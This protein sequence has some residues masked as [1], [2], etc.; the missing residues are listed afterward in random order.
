MLN[1]KL[2]V[3]CI[4]IIIAL[5]LY[6]FY[7]N[8]FIGFLISRVLRLFFWSQGKSAGSIWVDI[9]AF[10]SVITPRIRITRDIGSIHFSLLAGRILVKDVAYHSSN[11][12]IRMVKGQ[13][14]W[15]YWIRVPAGEEDL[16]QARVVGED[17]GSM[18][19]GVFFI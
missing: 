15:R 8:R 19:S 18:C 1:F 2:L 3:I 16:S 10:C 11:Q 5:T 4:C 13:I 7:W 17:V 6:L 9:G 14:S 12:T